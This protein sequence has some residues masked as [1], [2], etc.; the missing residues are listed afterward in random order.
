[1][2]AFVSV[3]LGIFIICNFKWQLF[4]MQDFCVK[5]CVCAC[6]VIEKE[7]VAF[8]AD[9]CCVWS[10]GPAFCLWFGDLCFELTVKEF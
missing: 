8:A 7:R 4:M 9:C 6:N 1:M 10:C 2:H 3:W 5:V